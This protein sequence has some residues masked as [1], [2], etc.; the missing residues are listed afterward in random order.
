MLVSEYGALIPLQQHGQ[1]EV[2]YLDVLDQRPGSADDDPASPRRVLSV[3]LRTG[4][5]TPVD[6][7]HGQV[8]IGE[9]N[10]ASFQLI[11]GEVVGVSQQP[12]PDLRDWAVTH[13]GGR[14][15]QAALAAQQLVWTESAGGPGHAP[16]TVWT[17]D[18]FRTDLPATRLARRGVPHDPVVGDGFVGW[19]D[20]GQ[21]MLLVPTSGGSPVRL[22]GRVAR[23]TRPAADRLLVAVV[24]RS[25]GGLA[26]T[27]YRVG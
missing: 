14:I 16:A 18:V 8:V 2:R 22:P 24:L 26:L 11:R 10:D 3:D 21:R 1:A 7:R 27:V 4:R 5:S 15:L 17:W 9:F 19:S 12:D 6:R 13:T 25:G 20:H 23:G